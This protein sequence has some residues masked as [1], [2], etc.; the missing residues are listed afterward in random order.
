VS[1]AGTR[2]GAE[3]PRGT[4]NET[5]WEQ[6]L[7]AAAEV[8]EE[9]G[10]PSATLQDIARRVGLLKGSLYYYI[11]SKE[12]LLFE[13]LR[14]GHAI[15]L[16]LVEE[17]DDVARAAPPARLA[18]FIERWTR[19]V[20]DVGRGMR[21]VERDVEYLSAD[22][23]AVILEMRD[24]V[25]GFV[26]SVVQTG[27]DAGCFDRE[28]DPAVVANNLFAVLNTTARWYRPSGALG[29]D[30]ILAWYQRLFLRGLGWAGAAGAEER[31]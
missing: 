30:E 28:A 17:P 18:A 1:R 10:Y 11:S 14:R 20:L 4:L 12:D 26:R 7:E 29:Q 6:V 24:R 19:G 23:R 22:R 25:S 21:F 31:R 15:G 3:A 9:K 16:S 5:R 2:T 8:F 13:I 27:V